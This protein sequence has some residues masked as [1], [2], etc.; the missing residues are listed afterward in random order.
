[1][2]STFTAINRYK[3]PAGSKSSPSR[4]LAEQGADYEN[5]AVRWEL[6]DRRAS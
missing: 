2:S 1:M 3:C 5:A 4:Q 6:H